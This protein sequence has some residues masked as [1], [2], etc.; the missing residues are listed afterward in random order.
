MI[1]VVE[2]FVAQPLKF[3][4]SIFYLMSRDAAVV[5]VIRVARQDVAG[6]L[7]RIDATWKAFAPGVPLRRE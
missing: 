2:N 7:A 1:G 6:T 3:G 4:A 5:P